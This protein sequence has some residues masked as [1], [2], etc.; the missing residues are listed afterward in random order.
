MTQGF[1]NGRY[2]GTGGDT[3][4]NSCVQAK[5]AYIA[6]QSDELSFS[7]GDMIVVQEKSS[8]GWWKGETISYR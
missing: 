2:N 1:E 8:D 7:K 3:S 6:Q 5:Y 4:G